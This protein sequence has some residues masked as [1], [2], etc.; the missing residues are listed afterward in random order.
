MNGNQELFVMNFKVNNVGVGEKISI[1]SSNVKASDGHADANYASVSYDVTVAAPLSGNTFLSNLV[2][3]N[4]TL[5]P[6][7]NKNTTSYSVSVPFSVAKINVTTATPEDATSKVA[8]SSPNLTAGGS[9][10]VSI[11]VTAQSG[12]KKTYTINVKRDQD[13]NY[14]ASSNNYLSS[15]TVDKGIL[16][17]VFSKDHTNYVIWL[18]FEVDNVA[19]SGK[20]EDAKASAA[21]V[22]GANLIAGQDNT[23]SVNCTAEDGSVKSYVVTAKRAANPDGTVSPSVLDANKINLDIT[24]AIHSANKKVNVDLSNKA[25]APVG[26]DVFKTLSKNAGVSLIFDL[27]KAKI[28]F[29]G[30]DIKSVADGTTYD[31]SFKSDSTYKTKMIADSKDNSAFVYSFSFHGN[32]PG[33]AT[34]TVYT[35]FEKGSVI[36]IYRYNTE[37][38]PSYSL[39]AKNVVVGEGGV[40]IYRNNTCSDYVMTSKVISGAKD[41]ASV[42]LQ[43]SLAKTNDSTNIW[44]FVLCCFLFLILGGALG[45]IGSKRLKL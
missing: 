19:V 18:P 34:I 35:N 4:G 30:S 13:P 15:I 16:S 10:V 36:N 22:G 8:I 31:L 5:A 32:L 21:T 6:A 20:A 23:I 37:G 40:V 11:M 7:F 1:S 29:A 14:K 9:T 27:G 45:F 33:Y 38:T 28:S 26:S 44:I 3:D 39:I 24:N 42:K 12:A 41:Y 25:T 43:G 17:P 2:I